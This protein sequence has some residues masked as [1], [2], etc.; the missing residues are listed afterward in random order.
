VA[1]GAFLAGATEGDAVEDRNVIADNS[2]FTHDKTG[3]V[4]EEET[5]A[6]AR[7]RID[8]RLENA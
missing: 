5:L 4:I 2:G 6:E 7:C 1:I 8:I 3:C